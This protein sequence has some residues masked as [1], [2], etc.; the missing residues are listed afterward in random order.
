[1]NKGLHRNIS[2]STLDEHYFF[3]YDSFTGGNTMADAP[4]KPRHVAVAIGWPE[5]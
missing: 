3:D 2:L 4:K 5:E 1:M